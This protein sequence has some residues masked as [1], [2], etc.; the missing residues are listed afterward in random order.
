MNVV[1]LDG[2]VCI[3]WCVWI[4]LERPSEQLNRMCC[5]F[6]CAHDTV[7]DRT[8]CVFLFL[9]GCHQCRCALLLLIRFTPNF[10]FF[11]FH[12]FLFLCWCCCC[13]Y[14]LASCTNAWRIT[15]AALLLQL[16]IAVIRFLQFNVY[17]V[18]MCTYI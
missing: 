3:W 16:Q 6:L 12:S 5:I 13:C 4:E 18:L 14:L 8:L 17:F 1:L 15:M 2:M 11:I 9:C 10:F 7:A